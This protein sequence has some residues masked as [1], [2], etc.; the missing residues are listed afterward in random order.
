MQPT[1]TRDRVSD[2]I[3]KDL[4]VRD[5]ARVL[6]ITTQAVYLHLKS[7]GIQPPTR[8]RGDQQKEVS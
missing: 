1:S 2:L 6:D 5:I 8:P 7:L 3:T 4:T